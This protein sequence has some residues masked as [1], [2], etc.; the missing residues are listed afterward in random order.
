[1]NSV[2]NS[3]PP[4]ISA[5]QQESTQSR[6]KTA[7]QKGVTHLSNAF[8]KISSFSKISNLATKIIKFVQI[9]FG[10]DQF[11]LLDVIKT[12]I[13]AVKN[14]ISSLKLADK[15]HDILSLNAQTSKLRITHKVTSFATSILKTIKFFG[16]LSLLDL[17]KGAAAIGKIPIF[18]IVSQLPLGIVINIFQFTLHVLGAI[19][20]ALN[21]VSLGKKMKTNKDSQNKWNRRSK[22]IEDI[23]SYVKKAGKLQE[24]SNSLQDPKSKYKTVDKLM[25]KETHSQKSVS[26][27]MR[28]EIPLEAPNANVFQHKTRVI[29]NEALVIPRDPGPF[30]QEAA[31]MS[32]EAAVVPRDPRLKKGDNIIIGAVHIDNVQPPEIKDLLAKKQELDEYEKVEADVRKEEKLTEHRPYSV[33]HV[34]YQDD[35]TG[36]DLDKMVERLHPRKD[37]QP[38]LDQ[39]T[40]A[41]LFGEDPLKKKMK[42]IITGLKGSDFPVKIE[43]PPLVIVV[44]KEPA[45]PETPK[46]PVQPTSP[47]PLPILPIVSLPSDPKIG[48]PAI[49]KEPLKPQD[50]PEPPLIAP[51]I[52]ASKEL[53]ILKEKLLQQKRF[54]DAKRAPL[55]EHYRKKIALTQNRIVFLQT[56]HANKVQLDPLRAKIFKW[57]HRVETIVGNDEKLLGETKR[58]YDLKVNDK[59][60]NIEILKQARIQ[61]AFSFSYRVAKVIVAASTI[62]LFF[63]G[64][65]TLVTS[66]GLITL[67]ALTYSFGIFKFFW[68]ETHKLDKTKGM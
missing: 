4:N 32:S 19:E 34:T 23:L 24:L 26:T 35:L 28:P 49:V 61:R 18:G 20:D 58:Q 13:K 67:T 10:E 31:D 5:G 56:K 64:I 52:E 48:P 68:Q 30:R 47:I 39:E 16:A 37:D 2:N 63:S 44:P 51:I 59:K 15:T 65:G 27:I 9:V 62:F 41:N 55:C 12:P 7:F 6:P 11:P 46:L 33:P 45:P 50:Q 25:I 1:M 42:P 14:V 3:L 53:K 60:V 22:E 17:G 38:T 57:E 36:S 40:M 21:F 8:S 54:L 43:Q 66:V 29:S